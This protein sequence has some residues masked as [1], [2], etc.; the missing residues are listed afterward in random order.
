MQD[1]I[2]RLDERSASTCG[3]VTQFAADVVARLVARD[4]ANGGALKESVVHRFMEAVRSSDPED[5]EAFMTELKRARIS[6][7][8]L[9]DVYIPEVARRL[10]VAWEEDMASFA[11]VTIGVAR[12]QAIL[13]DIGTN[14]MADTADRSF[15]ATVLMILPDSEQHTLGALVAASWLRRRGISVC[16]KM[17]PSLAD[18]AALLEV[19][20]FDGAMISI[21]C[22]EKLEVGARLVTT[23]KQETANGLRIAL[24]GA[25]VDQGGDVAAMTGAD[26]VTNDLSIAIQALGLTRTKPMLMDIT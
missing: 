5:V 25:V 2:F 3:G 8:T 14:W 18:I 24:G 13:R 9:A 7:A 15:G 10:G 12:L 6:H 19:R 17:A 4:G 26:I 23:I 1:G 20:H 22:Q 16:L 11:E 21:A